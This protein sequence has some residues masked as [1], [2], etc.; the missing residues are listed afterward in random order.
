MEMPKGMISLKDVNAAVQKTNSRKA[1]AKVLDKIFSMKTVER[2]MQVKLLMDKD[3][4]ET[5]NH[6]GPVVSWYNILLYRYYFPFYLND[7]SSCS[8]DFSSSSSS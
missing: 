4:V 2:A 1:Y 7:T 6:M 3:I 8:S 5:H